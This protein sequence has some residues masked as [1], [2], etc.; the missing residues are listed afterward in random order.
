MRYGSF[1]LNTARF[2]FLLLFAYDNSHASRTCYRS[3]S[4]RGAGCS[5]S[6]EFIGKVVAALNAEPRLSERSGK[7]VV[8][9]QLAKEL[10][11]VDTDGKQPVPLTLETV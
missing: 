5:E 6:P 11:V 3:L 4:G 8:A 1:A 10:G 2:D 7:V 9:A